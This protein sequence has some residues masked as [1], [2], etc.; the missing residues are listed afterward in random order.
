MSG[1]DL[2]SA[3]KK[4]LHTNHSL[5]N[6]G[7]IIRRSLAFSVFIVLMSVSQSSFAQVFEYWSNWMV[8]PGG[9]TTDA[10]PAAAIFNGTFN[11][12]DGCPP[13]RTIAVPKALHFR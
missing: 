2:R 7:S 1:N 5:S 10:A 12:T 4:P 11:N 3:V 6:R 9:G 8:I 13:K